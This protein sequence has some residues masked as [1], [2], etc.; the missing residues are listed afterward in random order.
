M[1]TKIVYIL[2]SL[3]E[4]TYI[5][6]AYL[7]IFS[8]R[9]WNPD[10]YIIL[11]TDNQTN[12]LFTGKREEILTYISEKIIIQFSDKSNMMYRSRW[13]KTCIRQLVTG[14]FLYIDCDTI[15]CKNLSPI[16]DIK[17]EIALVLDNHLPTNLYNKDL[18]SQCCLYA[19]QL[20]WCFPEEEKYYN[21]G[22]IYC[23]DTTKCHEFFKAWH[24]NWILSDNKGLHIDQPSLGLANIQFNHI[25]EQLP[26]IWNCQMYM[27]PIFAPNALIMHF[28]AFRN[29]SFMFSK[30]FLEYVKN[31]G[32]TEYVKSCLLDPL[33][34]VIS[35]TNIRSK[36]SLVDHIKWGKQFY[37][38]L[39]EYAK[40]IE[41]HFSTFP[42]R[43]CFTKFESVL[44]KYHSFFFLS[45]V[46]VS[47]SIIKTNL[48]MRRDNSVVSF[49]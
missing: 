49:H 43:T 4:K 35:F 23:K 24:Y 32:I 48:L 2:T 27:R 47:R 33:K 21:G 3:E 17:S 12:S 34:T 38:S 15:I 39:K 40:N 41:N 10:A 45:I 20:G 5:E 6:Q 16:D 18:L 9:Y 8:A 7:S 22:V 46:F 36:Y 14:D 31:N 26:G 19:E 37:F 25:I 13:I 30:E 44:L 42:W 1:K 29:D 28:W 11:I